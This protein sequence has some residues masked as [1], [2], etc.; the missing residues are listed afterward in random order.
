MTQSDAQEKCED[1]GGDLPIITSAAEN[2]FIVSLATGNGDPWLGMQAQDDGEF[3]WENCTPVADTFSNWNTGE[4]NNP[5]DERCAYMYVNGGH[6]V[7]KW[8]NNPC[9]KSFSAICQKPM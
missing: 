9:D 5:S 4:P 3:Y 1:L 7:G 8:N 2:S 6:Y